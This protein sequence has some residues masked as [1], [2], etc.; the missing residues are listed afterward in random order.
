MITASIGIASL[1]EP[2]SFDD[3]ER[4]VDA[5]DQ[6][7]YAAKHAGRNQ[8]AIHGAPMGDGPGLKVS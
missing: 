3:I 7:L 1:G 6:A 2:E 4:F 5:A 8:F